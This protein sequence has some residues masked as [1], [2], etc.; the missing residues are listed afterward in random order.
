MISSSCYDVREIIENV[1][2][3]EAAGHVRSFAG[4]ESMSES[5]FGKLSNLFKTKN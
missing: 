3:R 4:S 5:S 2:R 1:N